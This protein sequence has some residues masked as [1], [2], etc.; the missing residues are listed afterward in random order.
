MTSIEITATGWLST[1]QDLGR[2]GYLNC[3]VGTSGA[4]DR[5]SFRLANRLVGND[6]GA[7]AIECLLGGLAIRANDPI[8]ACVT[9]APAQAFVDG[10]PVGHASTLTLS[11]GQTLRLAAPAAGLRSYLA[12]RGGIDV[13]PVLGSRSTD[14][15]SGLGPPALKCGDVISLGGEARDYPLVS[16]A[17]IPPLTTDPLTLQL[18]LGP[19][20]DWFTN[21]K[22]LAA[23]LWQASS[24]SDRI[25]VRLD[26][27]DPTEAPALVRAREGELLS[28]GLALGAVQIP[29]SGQPV[30]FLADHPVTGGY[31]VVGVVDAADLDRASQARP[32]QLIRFF[33][34]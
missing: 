22:D 26:R 33:I 16:V 20:D 9:G 21:P 27:H 28:E 6:E 17:P 31:P 4:A 1:V 25:G 32:G 19:R 3:G 30:I 18:T 11:A 12:C 13:E 7:A 2:F 29:P 5:T 34:T 10:T 14:T 23:G 24:Q 8:T 15:L